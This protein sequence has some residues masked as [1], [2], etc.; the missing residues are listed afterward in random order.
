M[1]GLY[2]IPLHG[3]KEGLHEYNFEIDNGFFE[4]FEDSEIKE[5]DLYVHVALT[6]RTT[7]I[8]LVFSISGVVQVCCDRCLEMFACPV[9]SEYRLLI[10][11]GKNWDEDDPDLLTIPTD[12]TELDLSQYLYEFIHLSLPIKRI[13]PDDADGN[14]TCDPAMLKKIMEHDAGNDKATDPRWDELKKLMNN[15]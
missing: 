4:L 3:L 2:A 15:N 7:H 10:R 12:E 14:S 6:R 11:I 13:H 8:D 5:G 9:K 1:S